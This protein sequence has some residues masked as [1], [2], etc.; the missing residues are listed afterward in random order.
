[1]LA[2][3]EISVVEVVWGLLRVKGPVVNRTPAWA[4]YNDD[5]NSVAVAST[6]GGGEVFKSS[7]YQN[8]Q[9]LYTRPQVSSTYDEKPS[10]RLVKHFFKFYFYLLFFILFKH[11]Q[12]FS[13][14]KNFCYF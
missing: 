12:C 5:Y 10:R 14:F 11:F 8:A 3:N 9:A 2:K 1:M 6:P 7:L 13:Y 4:I